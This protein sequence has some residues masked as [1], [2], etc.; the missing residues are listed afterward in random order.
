MTLTGDYHTHTVYSHGKGSVFDNARRAKEIGLGEIAISDHGFAQMAFGLRRRQLPQLIEDCRA[1]GRETG[2]PVYVG[3][4]ANICGESGKTDLGEQD[5]DNFDVFL[6]GMHRFVRFERW[7]DAWNL[8]AKNY[9]DCALRLRPGASLIRS[10]TGAYIR[11]IQKNPL[12]AVTHLNFLCF[13]DVAEVAKAARDYGTYIELN[14]KKVH[15]TDE[16]LARVADTGVRFIVG[17]DAH[18]PDRIGDTKLVDEQLAR[19]GFPRERID[20]IDGR[21]PHFRFRAFKE[22]R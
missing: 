1:A 21:K 6:A 15:L 16:E 12:D 4:E 2:I 11:C 22:G 18:S 20:N 17:S 10:N 8:L 19:I 13:C 3:I 7:R 9:A 14:S 5:Y